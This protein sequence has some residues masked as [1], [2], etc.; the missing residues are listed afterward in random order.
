MKRLV[1]GV[2]LVAVLAAAAVAA[3]QE[4]YE[5]SYREGVA[6]FKARDYEACRKAMAQALDQAEGP[7]EQAR[8]LLYVGR[9]WHAQKNFKA[10]REACTK[11]LEMKNLGS[12]RRRDALALTAKA[13][14]AEKN[15]AAA[16]EALSKILKM[17]RL[18]PAVTAQTHLDLAL[19]YF[20]E[21]NLPK[22]HETFTKVIPVTEAHPNIRAV[23][24][25]FAARCVLKDAAKK[26][27]TLATVLTIAK[28][29]PTYL[30]QA[31]YRIARTY[32]DE[33]N[34]PAAKAEFDRLLK[35]D[36]VGARTRRRAAQQLRKIEQAL[37]ETGQGAEKKTP[38][39]ALNIIP[40]PQ[41]YSAKEGRLVLVKDGRPQATIV[42]SEKPDR[43]E[44]LAAE[45]IARDIKRLCGVDVP[46][47]RGKP[48]KPLPG[49]TILIGDSA[50][51]H[52]GLALGAPE[53]EFLKSEKTGQGYVLDV[54]TGAQGASICIAGSSPQGTLFGAMT[55][56]QM[57][58]RAGESLVVR[59]ALIRDYPDF[60]DREVGSA[61]VSSPK[62]LKAARDAVDFALRH[63]VNVVATALPR[64]HYVQ[65]AGSVR[66]INAYARERGM[67]GVLYMVLGE[68]PPPDEPGAPLL[69]RRSY[70]DGKIYRCMGQQRSA[71]DRDT[72]RWCAS[73]DAMHERMARNVAAY[74]RLM[75]PGHVELHHIDNDRWAHGEQIWKRRCADCRKRWPS[76]DLASMQGLAGAQVYF[77]DRVIAAI[78]SVRNADSRY[79]ARRD[80]TMRIGFPVYTNLSED[81]ATWDREVGF[82]RAISAGLK[83]KKNVFFVTREQGRRKDDG[84][85]RFMQMGEALRANGVQYMGWIWAG[86]R[87][88]P[89]WPQQHTHHFWHSPLPAMLK[90]FE[91]ADMVLVAGNFTPMSQLIG[92]EY[93]WNNESS[94]YWRDPGHDEWHGTFRSLGK[95]RETPPAIYGPGGFVERAC[96]NMVGEK[97]GA[98]LAKGF[99]ARAT[100]NRR[101]ITPMFNFAAKQTIKPWKKAC[102]DGSAKRPEVLAGWEQVWRVYEKVGREA[103]DCFRKA[104]KQEGLSLAVPHV[105]FQVTI[106][107]GALQHWSHAASQSAAEAAALCA[108]AKKALATAAAARK[109]EESSFPL[110]PRKPK[111]S[112]IEV[113]VFD[114]ATYLSLGAKPVA[115]ALQGMQ[116]LKL[117]FLDA[118]TP[119]A[120]AKC[121]VL[122]LH[123]C[124]PLPDDWRAAA[125]RF[126]GEG[127]GLLLLHDAVGYR[128]FGPSLFPEIIAMAI[129]HPRINRVKVVG[130]HPVTKGLED[131]AEFRHSYTDHILMQPGK[132]GVV[133][134]GEAGTEIGQGVQPVLVVGEWGHGR[135]AFSG[136]IIGYNEGGQKADPEEGLILMNLIRWLAE[137]RM[138]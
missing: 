73:N 62:A 78:Q 39:G 95:S 116:G 82:Y 77:W 43:K 85:K 56:L 6:K 113:G 118:L 106:L 107:A 68:L 137:P 29:S 71:K 23:A 14:T 24:C 59:A 83:H 1:S 74:I 117:R 50:I 110:A 129:E 37:R 123:S 19:T 33:K 108:K 133:L 130:R 40:T 17:K 67:R 122:L 102:R 31:R 60:R 84:R 94:G 61:Y 120:L 28:V 100:L 101:T 105:R 16:R 36:K 7:K 135:V 51:K 131:G 38:D 48:A 57:I 3:G 15:Y 42:L 8:V 32:M 109:R 54:V 27:E 55:L 90:A 126:V 35:M 79:D 88:C 136:I 80:L 9:A 96:R 53:Q 119:D 89:G 91:G 112:V 52:A 64:K 44:E 125:V 70:P 30:V 99:L 13:W 63:K 21:R 5:K 20:Y 45:Y 69:N 46:V 22:A 47:V 41:Q 4:A 97:A 128:R 49:G 2:A 75:E 92:A 103:A 98:D 111:G 12:A 115:E 72:T 26:R 10:A 86:G 34:Y 114:N 138:Q 25:F 104:M 18:R 66:Q 11:V 127:R 65:N 87:E 121:D 93:A 134:L 76:D 81:D 132:R 58:E 124:K